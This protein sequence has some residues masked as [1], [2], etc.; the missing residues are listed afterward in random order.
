MIT[1]REDWIDKYE[2]SWNIN[3]KFKYLNQISG[4][5][6][7]SDQNLDIDDYI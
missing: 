1:W 4:K 6:K 5:N 2:S 7:V 3:E